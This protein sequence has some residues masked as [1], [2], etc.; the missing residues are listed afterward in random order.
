MKPA[1]ELTSAS[2]ST[3]AGTKCTGLPSTKG[4]SSD[5]TLKSCG[6]PEPSSAMV[7]SSWTWMVAPMSG[8][9]RR[10]SR[11]RLWPT[12]V[13]RSPQTMRLVGMSVMDDVA[14]LH[15]L[16]RDLGVLGVGEAVRKSGC[17]ARITMLPSVLWT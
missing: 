12:L 11:L 13:M 17:G 3:C 7:A 8:R 16:E 10:I 15:L 1:T 14:R 4:G 6:A 5:R 9:S 2:T